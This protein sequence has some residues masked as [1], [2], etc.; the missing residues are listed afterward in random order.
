MSEWEAFGFAGQFLRAFFFARFEFEMEMEKE[1]KNK[2][3]ERGKWI[4]GK[5]DDSEDE[6][7]LQLPEW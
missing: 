7:K 5:M 1:K 3:Q 6:I 2:K 4:G